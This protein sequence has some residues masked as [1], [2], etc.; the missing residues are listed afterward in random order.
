MSVSDNYAVPKTIGNGSTVDFTFNWPA[1]NTSYLR[2]YLEDAT[3]GIQVLQTEGGGAD[4]TVVLTST[5]GTV[6]FNTAPTSADYVVISRVVEQNQTDP[7]STSKGFQGDV[8]ED[9]FDKI[10]LISQDQQDALDRS[11]T[12]QVGSSSSTDMPEPFADA[13]IG[14][15]DS[16]TTLENKTN[17]A[18]TA[19]LPTISTPADANKLVKLNATGDDYEYE[20]LDI[21]NIA[22]GTDG[23][24]ITWDAAGVAATVAA[25]TSSQVLTSNGAGAAP[26]M[27]AL[28][29][30]STTVEGIV[31]LGTN[32]EVVTGT[33]PARVAPISAMVHHQGVIKAWARIT[34]SGGVPSISD[35]YNLT[36]I[37]DRAVGRYTLNWSITMAN[38]NY[39]V[40]IGTEVDF[41]NT[42]YITGVDTDIASTTTA[43]PIA[44]VATIGTPADPRE[45][46]V[47]IIGD[48]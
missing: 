45:F 24:L 23:E 20:K 43:T 18:S 39:A 47:S 30:A 46:T 12:F 13:L 7:Y 31:E 19:T 36:S 2:V 25:G 1:L 27:Q 8:V 15:N 40:I 41:G 35:S 42:A 37:T 21:D 29:S 28:P 17:G 6:T 33:D 9:S 14:W 44:V 10:T 11:I 3:T 16:G 48:I 5:G 26:T 4:Y 32:A 38:A 34:V 22:D